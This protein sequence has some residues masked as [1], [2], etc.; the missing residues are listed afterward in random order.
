M[1]AGRMAGQLPR[2]KDTSLARFFNALL[3]NVFTFVLSVPIFPAI[4]RIPARTRLPSGSQHEY[5]QLMLD[6]K[7]WNRKMGSPK[8]QDRPGN[9]F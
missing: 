7:T 1:A 4:V 5:F 8:S 9:L 2:S 6:K 3:K